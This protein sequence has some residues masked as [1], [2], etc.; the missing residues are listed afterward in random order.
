MPRKTIHRFLPDIGRLI[1]RPSLRWISRISHDPNL[2]HLNR[3]SVSLAVFIGILCAF[4]PLPGQTIIAAFMCFWLGANL[5]IGVVVI[6][7]SNPI[8]IPPMFYLTHQ[9]GSFLLGSEPVNFTV[10]LNW[11]WFSNVGSAILLPLVT[12]SLLCGIILASIGYFFILN[13]WRWKV[14]KNWERRKDLRLEQQ[15]RKS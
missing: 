3:H 4:I 9:L 8:T 11:E 12:G 10:A 1:Q 15:S 2:L 7:I 14:I 5:P 6:W 13:L